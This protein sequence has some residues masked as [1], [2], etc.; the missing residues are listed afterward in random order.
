LG[1]DL[2]P[3]KK[4]EPDDDETRDHGQKASSLSVQPP[5]RQFWK[6]D[7]VCH[8]FFACLRNEVR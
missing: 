4:E 1:N 8:N 6:V 3:L 7:A 5:R 2:D